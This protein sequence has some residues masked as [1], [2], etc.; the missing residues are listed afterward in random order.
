MAEQETDTG[1]RITR[2]WAA[3]IAAVIAIAG[4]CWAYFKEA[5]LNYDTLYA[6]I[7]GRDLASGRLPDYEVTLAPTPHPLAEAVG[8]LASLFGTEA[9]Y[10]IILALAMLAFGAFVWGVLL[11]GRTCFGWP[12]GVIAA[13]VVATRVPFLSFGMRAYVDIPFLALIV[14]AALIEVRSPRRGT[15]V[16]ILLGLA[17]LLRPEAWFLSAVYIAYLWPA[18]DHRE[19][20]RSIAIALGAPLIW[21][22]S[23]L[24]ATGSALHSLTSTR[25]TSALL[26]RPR[27]FLKAFEIGPRRIGEIMRVVAGGG[28]V[29]GLVLGLKYLRRRSAVPAALLVLSGIAFLVIG[30]AGLSLIGRYLFMPASMLAI[31]F[32]VACFGWLNLGRDRHP[33]RRNWMIGGI[34]LALVFVSSG[35]AHQA[36][37]IE[38]VR[39]GIEL[40]G[41]VQDDLRDLV[42]GG[43]AR[44]A[45]R[46]CP[47]VYVPNHR[48]VP[49]LAWYVD[50]QPKKFVPRDPGDRGPGAWLLPRTAEVRDKFVL[51]PNDPVQANIPLVAPPDWTRVGAN[52]SW[53]LY[54]RD[55]A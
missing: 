29:A 23:D 54:T 41:K 43:S 27:G 53:Q 38:K 4:L 49:I 50:R 17:G 42:D 32:G 5:F 25:D 22:L 15:P 51:D 34:A 1:S 11:L 6:L 30:I 13:L 46:R 2:L 37:R 35:I 52:E 33:I 26:E 40:R 18:Q 19:R 14:F 39:N 7:W 45:A 8:A 21:A 47:V 20:Y 10:T 3:Q 48:P 55:C 36:P 12:V 44:A 24:A 16:L 31:F 9:A 28:G